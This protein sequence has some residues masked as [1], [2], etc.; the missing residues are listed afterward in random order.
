M[1][2]AARWAAANAAMYEIGSQAFG[3]DM[4]RW[5]FF[6][7]FGYTGGPMVE[8]AGQA[9]STTN[10]LVQGQIDMTG[11][12]KKGADPADAIALARFKNSWQQFVPLPTGQYNRTMRALDQIQLGDWSKGTKYFLGFPPIK[13]TY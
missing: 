13:D 7:P 4:G 6:S 12:A 10:M 1:K 2:V 8:V 3:V 9:L 5:L 11:Q